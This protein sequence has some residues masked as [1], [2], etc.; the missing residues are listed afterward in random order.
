MKKNDIL[1]LVSLLASPAALI[2][3]GLIL[4]FC[5]DSVSVFAAKL[6][7]WILLAVGI[8]FAAAA[9]TGSSGT[10]SNVLC[11]I[12]CLAVG[13]WLLKSPLL[14]A[15]SIGRFVGILLVIRGI[16]DFAQSIYRQGKLLA[17]ITAVLGVVLI[18][19][20]MTTSRVVFSACGLVVLVIGIAMLVDRL[21]R[22]R[23]PGGDNDP[24]IIDAL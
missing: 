10:A 16:R 1:S 20:P 8:G 14:L 11:A 17:L 12:A 13:G 7:G 6:L 24:N 19:L 5:P 15:K 9:F 2:L 21:R 23:L 4:L 18:A 22:R 3:L